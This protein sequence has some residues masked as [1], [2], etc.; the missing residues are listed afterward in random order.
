METEDL[1]CARYEAEL[2][3]IAVLDR[4]CYLNPCPTR[5]DRAAYAARQDQLGD[6]RS[7]FY[8]ELALVANVSASGRQNTGNS[9]TSDGEYPVQ[10]CPLNRP[11][12]K[13]RCTT[14]IRGPKA[15]G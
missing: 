3:V 8:A 14:L 6:I 12:L 15:H 2:A 1:I 5:S 9:E 4:L 13:C 7:R 11:V 10:L